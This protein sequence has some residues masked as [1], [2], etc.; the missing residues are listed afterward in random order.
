[1]EP[2]ISVI[3][4][5]IG[6]RARSRIL[7]A[8]MSGKALT[9]TELACEAEISAQTASNH[10]SKLVGSNLLV[11]RK[12]GRHKYFQLA[13]H[14]VAETLEMLLNLSST[15]GSQKITT[16]PADPDLKKS[17]ICYDHLAGV[18]GVALYDAL[19]GQ[20]MI[21]ENSQNITLTERGELFFQKKGV[22]V[23]ELKKGKRPICKSCLDW[24]ERK[25]HLAGSLGQWI[26]EDALAKQWAS[27]RLD[28]RV[29][30]FSKRGVSQ[31]TR[32][33]Q[34]EPGSFL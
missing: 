6:D 26:L 13:N 15:L 16:G 30:T 1:M 27:R 31:F 10:L 14:Q 18:T 21:S 29:I 5:L 23:D 8:L 12:Q 20:E 33:Y 34:I 25:S 32:C 28:S 17:R 7:M 24:S 3:S 11:V 9:A 22:A 4:S 19:L 2:D